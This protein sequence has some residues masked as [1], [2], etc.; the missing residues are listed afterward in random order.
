MKKYLLFFTCIYLFS[1]A[2]VSQSMH[3]NS[4]SE[5]QVQGADN[6]DHFMLGVFLGAVLLSD[7]ETIDIAMDTL[8]DQ[9]TISPKWLEA[10]KDALERAD[11]EQDQE[12]A[13]HVRMRLRLIEQSQAERAR[14][15]GSRDEKPTPRQGPRL[16]IWVEIIRGIDASESPIIEE[17]EGFWY[18]VV[19]QRENC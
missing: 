10:I 15:T 11:W 14:G 7:L 2:S 19:P 8:M 16:P 13:D 3:Q 17:E 12:T 18:R 6:N 4:S 1:G 5:D 9:D